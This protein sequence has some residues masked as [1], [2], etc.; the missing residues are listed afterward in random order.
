MPRTSITA[1]DVVVINLITSGIVVNNQNVIGVVEMKQVS[2]NF[3][4]RVVWQI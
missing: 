2:A 4:P 3:L 1:L